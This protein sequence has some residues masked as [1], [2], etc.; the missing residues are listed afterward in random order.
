MD[1]KNALLL[2]AAQQKTNEKQQAVQNQIAGAQAQQTGYNYAGSLGNTAQ[3]LR[4]S[5]L[6]GAAQYAQ[7]VQVPYSNQYINPQ[8][9]MPEMRLLYEEVLDPET[10][11]PIET[12]DGSIVMAPIPTRET[13]IAFTKADIEVDTVAYND[14]DE[15]NQVILEQFI[16]G[17]IGNTL[18]QVNPSGYFKASELAMRNIKSKYSK[19]IGDIL[20]ETVQILGGNMQM[21]QQM[22]QGNMQ[23]QMSPD[24]MMNQLPG[25][26]TQG[27]R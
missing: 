27:G 3:G 10:L 1:K 19:E 13:E 7:P 16:N 6:Q 17:P 21:Q 2:D 26:P 14:E 4:Q 25:R 15:R 23:G 20:G 11:K 18:S 8:T 12:E 9:G 24:Q 5:G 22:Q